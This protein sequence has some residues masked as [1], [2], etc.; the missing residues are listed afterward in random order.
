M[1]KVSRQFIQL[2]ISCLLLGLSSPSFAQA[3]LTKTGASFP[4]FNGADISAWKPSGNATWIVNNQEVDVTQ[5]AGTLVSKLSV[6]DFQVEFDYWVS[7]NAQASIYFRCTNTNSINAE[8][9]Y[10]VP[11]T[12]QSKTVGAGSIRLLSNLRDSQVAQQ[13]NHILISGNG[14]QLSVTLNGVVNQAVDTRHNKGPIAID[15]QGGELR[16][17][18]MNFIIPGRW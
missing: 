15:F 16:L 4:M 14:S 1:W 7:N 11:L 12:N 3:I 5:G 6:P 9:A 13:W 10:E 18:N 2:G 8:T 17:K